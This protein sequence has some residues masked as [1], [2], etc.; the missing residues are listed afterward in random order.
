MEDKAGMT[1]EPG[2]RL[3]M[4]MRSV[5]VEDHMNDPAD[6]DLGLDRVQ[7]ADEFLV[8]VTLHAAPNDLTIEHVEGGEQGCGAVSFIVMR[9]R[10]GAAPLQRQ[11]GLGAVESLDLALLIDRE[12]DG[13]RRGIN[14]KPNDVAQLGGELRV[15]GQCV[16]SPGGSSWMSAI[17]RS[18]T[19]GPKGGMREG[20][21]LSRRSPSMPSRMK[22]SCQ[23]H[24]Q[25][26]LLLVGRMI[27]T[28]PRPATV[29]RMIRARQTCF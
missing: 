6:R 3:G 1:I 7:K 13:M 17:T 21:V 22:R 16:V 8:P 29:S 15:G 12:H 24:T 18:A 14:V 4:L 23:R 19:C 2:P 10:A 26:L 27:S 25:V 11:S 28:V 20:R 5:I 9:H